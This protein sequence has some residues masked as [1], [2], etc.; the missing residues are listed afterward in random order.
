[1]HDDRSPRASINHITVH[2][3][4][5]LA[6]L[7]SYEHKHNE[8][9]GEGNRDGSDDN[10]SI[11]C[12]VEGLTDNP[13][14]LALRRQLRCNFVASLMLAQG[15]PLLLAAAEVANSQNGDKKA[16]CQDN[17]IGWGSECSTA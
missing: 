4:F 9:N 17:E 16:Y 11:N 15:T 12:G 14:I 1:N 5:T 6:D 10:N 2:D 13:E 8:A 7:V 3:G